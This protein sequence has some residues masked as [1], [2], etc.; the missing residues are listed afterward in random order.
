MRR[1]MRPREEALN[2]CRIGLLPFLVGANPIIFWTI[3]FVVDWFRSWFFWF[4]V[5]L[6]T[7]IHDSYARTKS[8]STD[9]DLVI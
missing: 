3:F 6:V 8:A 7:W 5:E 1:T 9:L 4:S 2:A